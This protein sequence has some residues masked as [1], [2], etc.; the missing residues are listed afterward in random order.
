MH[1]LA[2]ETVV[3]RAEELLPRLPVVERGVVLARHEANVLVLEALDDI[4]ELGQTPASL[5]GIIRGVREV[6]GEDYEVR[7]E[8]EAVHRGDR[9][10]Q[11]AARV[12]IHDRPVEAPVRVGKLDEV[13]VVLCRAGELG[14]ACEAGGEHHAT[15]PRQLQKL[16]PI[17]GLLH[18]RSPIYRKEEA[19]SIPAI[20]CKTGAAAVLFPS[21]RDCA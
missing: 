11:R 1:T 18:F 6:A 21:L 16:S 12:R 17:N 5:L 7:L 14:T 10:V 4:A 19:G 8:L 13:E 3:A 20:S 15:Q 9:L 2:V